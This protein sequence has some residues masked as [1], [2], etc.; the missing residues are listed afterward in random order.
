MPGTRMSCI[1]L[2]LIESNRRVSMALQ[3]TAEQEERQ[4]SSSV[5]RS[6]AWYV[7][8]RSPAGRRPAASRGPAGTRTRRE[9]EQRAAEEAA[10]KR[11]EAETQALRA[12]ASCSRSHRSATVC[13]GSRLSLKYPACLTRYAAI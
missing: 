8:R 1:T 9:K 6:A 12:A 5:M 13:A 3:L 2:R 11:A 7:C 4:A 10:R